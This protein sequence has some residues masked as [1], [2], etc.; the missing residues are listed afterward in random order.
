M[1]FYNGKSLKDHLGKSCGKGNCQ[2]CDFI[3]NTDTFSTR[4]C[5]EALK[6]QRGAPNCNSQ[7]VVYLL[8]WRIS[9]EDPYVLTKF[10]ATFNNYKSA[11]RS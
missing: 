11:H 4:A 5:G 2:V 3:C 9:G 6:I 8:K 7:R 1:G 10:R